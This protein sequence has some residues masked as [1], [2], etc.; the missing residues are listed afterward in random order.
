MTAGACGVMV[1][2]LRVGTTAGDQGRPGPSP[3]GSTSSKG[4]CSRSRPAMSVIRI[5][6]SRA[7]QAGRSS[8]HSA[9]PIRGWGITL[10]G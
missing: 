10:V 5:T 7:S 1:A 2:G 9:D 8:Y 6:A 3:V 4:R